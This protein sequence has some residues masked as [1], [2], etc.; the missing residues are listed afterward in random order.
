MS[1]HTKYVPRTDCDALK[2][3]FGDCHLSLSWAVYVYC[4]RVNVQFFSAWHYVTQMKAVYIQ[5]LSRGCIFSY[6][7]I[8]GVK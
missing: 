7:F 1:E 5:R 2:A 3:R 4:G 6:L 8:D